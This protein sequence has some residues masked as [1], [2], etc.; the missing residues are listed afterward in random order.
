MGN[1]VHDCGVFVARGL[2]AHGF[3][4]LA[5]HLVHVLDG[6]FVW[7]LQRVLEF[8]VLRG[9]TRVVRGDLRLVVFR[10]VNLEA[11]LFV[12]HQGETHLGDGTSPELR[13]RHQCLSA[14]YLLDV[15]LWLILVRV[16]CDHNVNVGDFAGDRGGKVV[17]LGFRVPAGAF[18]VLTG[19][20]EGNHDVSAGFF[21]LGSPLLCRSYDVIEVCLAVEVLL[22]PHC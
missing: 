7:N 21:C 17:G 1:E 5:N 15:F 22:V 10:P 14:V 3:G 4:R 19:V 8:F 16:P 20:S 2:C 18:R 9:V 6:L 13:L 11:T 12:R